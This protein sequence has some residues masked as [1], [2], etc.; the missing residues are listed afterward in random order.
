MP[1][2]AQEHFYNG[3]RG[4]IERLGMQP[5]WDE[6]I[7]VLTGYDLRVAEKKD[8][9]GGAAVRKI[10]DARFDA[11]G[12]WQKKVSGDVDWTKCKRINGTRVCLGVEIQFSA[13]SDLLIVD[14]VHLREAITAG[15]IDLGV[16]VAPSSTLRPFLTDRGPSFDAALIAVSRAGAEDLPLAVL[17]IEH[18]GPGAALAKERT[19]QGRAV[20]DIGAGEGAPLAADAAP[21]YEKKPRKPRVS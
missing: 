15:H 4:K 5:L 2:V 6:L 1:K 12:G 7:D 13:R 11:V 3:A 16:I 9:N 20:A 19:R 10:V 21:T 8:S 14:V 17:G 18:D